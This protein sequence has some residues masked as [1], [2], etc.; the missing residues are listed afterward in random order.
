MNAQM[1]V[2]AVADDPFPVFPWPVLVRNPRGVLCIDVYRAVHKN[3][4]AYLTKDEV[5][6]FSAFKL[7]M[8]EEACSQRRESRLMGREWN[9]DEDGLRRVDYL[10][11]RVMF[12]GLE[13][14]K[15]GGGSW[16][17]HLG[18]PGPEE[19]FD[20]PYMPPPLESCPTPF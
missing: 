18:P 3:F 5:S 4:Q 7:R 14:S 9:D 17:L 20:G 10:V 8:V 11:D 16:V 6:K 1:L 12:R 19:K 15:I 13:P 2:S